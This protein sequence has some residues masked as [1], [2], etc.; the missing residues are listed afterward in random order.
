MGLWS[1]AF[2]PR[3]SRAIDASMQTP[4]LAMTRDRARSVAIATDPATQTRMKYGPR[5]GGVN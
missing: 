1:G 2:D 5:A 3:P 4:A